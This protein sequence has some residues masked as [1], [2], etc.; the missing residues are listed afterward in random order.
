MN[1]QKNPVALKTP[2]M[3]LHIMRPLTSFAPM[4]ATDVEDPTC[5]RYNAHPNPVISILICRTM[6]GCISSGLV[7]QNLAAAFMV[8]A[9]I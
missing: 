2:P 4:K 6:K 1:V 3:A 9:T 7:S 8:A 5:N